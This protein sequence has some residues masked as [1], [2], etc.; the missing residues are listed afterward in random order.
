[1]AERD[2]GGAPHAE[3]QRERI[4]ALAAEMASALDRFESLRV[5]R[6]YLFGGRVSAADLG[7]FPFLKY[8]LFREKE[9]DELF[10]RILDEHQSLGDEHPRLGSWIR[11][12]GALPRR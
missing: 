8:A 7:A 12:I 4:A 2:R 5:G 1:M 9:D 11:R 6:E 3:P 10:H